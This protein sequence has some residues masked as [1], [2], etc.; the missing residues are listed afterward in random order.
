VKKRWKRILPAALAAGL[1]LAALPVSGLAAS[2][3]KTVDV[4]YRDIKLV[5]DG[6]TVTPRDAAGR[7]AE[8]FLIGGTTYLPL[9]AVA[10]ALDMEVAWQDGAGAVTIVSKAGAPQPSAPG[11]GTPGTVGKKTVDITYRDIKLYVDG[12]PV[13]PRDAA[14]AVVEPFLLNDTVYLPLRAVAEAL[15]RSV[16]W[17]QSANTASVTSPSFVTVRTAEELIGAI[18]SDTDILLLPGAYDITAQAA[19]RA[20]QAVWWEEVFDGVQLNVEGVKN[21]TLRAS[22]P[23]AGHLT[24][25]PRYAFVMNFIRCEKVRLI[26]LKAGHTE[27]GYG[28]G[29]VFGFKDCKDVT[30]DQIRMYGAAEGLSLAGVSGVTVTRSEIYAC[31]YGI[32]TVENS[33]NVRFENCSFHDNGALDLIALDGVDGFVIDHSLIVDNLIRKDCVLFRVSGSRDLTVRNT[34]L[35]ENGPGALGG[36]DIAF[37]NISHERPVSTDPPPMQAY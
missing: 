12:L 36:A 4:T 20:P 30:L 34:V 6:V 19:A 37:E 23:G 28:Q 24:V 26:N 29:G 2:G 1:L 35:A 15:G 5:I 16:G 9:R 11:D 21:L 17:D 3:R 10:E 18:A 32:M 31:A 33:L 7:F 22:A 8:P 27:E 14:G 25:T 13:I